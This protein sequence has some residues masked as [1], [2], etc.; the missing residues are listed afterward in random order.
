MAGLHIKVLAEKLGTRMRSSPAT[1][2]TVKT[3]TK[4]ADIVAQIARAAG[5]VKINRLSLLAHGYAETWSGGR[6]RFANFT[7]NMPYSK[8]GGG[9]GLQLGEDID[10]T[11][12]T[13]FGALKPHL[14]PGA[15][16]DVYACFAADVSPDL[17]R[18]SLI[19][20]GEG[21]MRALAFAT[22][23]MVRA[24]KSAHNFR[25]GGSWV[26]V[27]RFEGQV[28][29]FRPDGTIVPEQFS[30]VEDYD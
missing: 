17:P 26:D 27:G 22:G 25:S 8:Q 12:I 15:V 11:S 1:N 18:A 19:G 28:L 20:D 5:G 21:T 24:S 29:Q 9:Y 23:A 4:V 10:R 30:R 2:I 13:G 7:P 16:I 6:N 14:A 3:G